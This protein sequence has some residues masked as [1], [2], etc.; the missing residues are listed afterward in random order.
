MPLIKLE[1]CHLHYGEQVL[2]DNLALQLDRGERL[3]IVGRNGVG[4]STLLKYIAGTVEADSGNRW[5][6]SGVRVASLSQEL[7]DADNTSVFEF[8]AAGLA[9][10]GADLAR[11]EQ[12][13]AQ[14]ADADL[15]AL[16]KVQ[17]RIESADGWRFQSRIETVLSRLE[18]DGS[19][20]MQDLSGGWRR[21][22][23]L[24]QAL[25]CEPDVLLLD[26][27]TN[28]LDIAAIQWLELQLQQ[29][30]GAIVFITHDRAFLRAVANRI[31]E[32]DRGDL[33][34][35]QGDYE[36]F[37]EFRQQQLDAEARQNALF[38]KKLAEEET[39]IRQGIKARRTRNEGR[40]RALE[41]MREERAQ[42]R[43]VSAT[44]RI[45]H[46]GDSISGKLVAELAEVSFAWP[47]KTII[48]GFSS[49]ILRG[50]KIG[51]IGP[52]GI[53]KSTLLKLILGELEPQQGRVKM[54]TKLSVAYFDQLRLQ[55][56]LDKSAVD[57]ISEGRD[58]IEINGRPRHIMSYLGDFLFS[59]ERARTPIKTL[60]GG[61]R[62][63]ILLA[64]LFSKPSNLLVMDEPTNDLDAE[65]LELLESILVEYSGTLLLV[66][67]DREFLN[68]VVTSTIAFEGNGRV[69]EY[70]GGF[71]D[72]LRQGG[73]W[74][75]NDASEAAEEV[76]ASASKSAVQTPAD[77]TKARPAKK[78]SYKLQRELDALPAELEALEADIASHEQAVSSP[79]F[80][81]QDP[82]SVTARLQ[83]LADLQAALQQRY[84]RWE[85][86]EALQNGA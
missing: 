19:T 9:S 65:T 4:K 70:V 18:L 26:E 58:T 53:G 14:G 86:L 36:G 48:D 60:S 59:G 66:S 50:D 38:D 33:S 1:N 32:L 76:S 84:D 46:G 6:D 15:Q 44:A 11:F 55:L 13:V 68:N 27:P 77:T 2:F 71:D 63:R 21:R 78:L 5:L 69:R 42:R 23:A 56:D 57:N 49:T 31:G 74:P 3:C 62:N 24:A 22:A 47:D 40:V 8:V 80:Y 43:E 64:K 75:E 52:N 79:D 12:L 61:E 17:Q 72:W 34:L 73:V 7:P 10:L 45:E 28:H 25:V 85:E 30:N 35:W 41:K 67:H 82:D 20:R 54:G 29:F 37:L 51:L 16:E 39:W 83:E 81:S